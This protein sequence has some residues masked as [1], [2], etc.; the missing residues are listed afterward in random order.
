MKKFFSFFR[1]KLSLIFAFW[2]KK[3][4]QNRKIKKTFS[5]K[6]AKK[7][8]YFNILGENRKI[9]INFFAT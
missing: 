4:V 7:L 9:T 6:N 3:N 8:F 2:T 1:E 5:A